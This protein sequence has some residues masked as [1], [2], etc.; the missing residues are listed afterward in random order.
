RLITTLHRSQD[1]EM[2]GILRSTL[3]D[4]RVILS[5]MSG[6]SISLVQ[7]L[8]DLRN[9]ATERLRD[10]G[11]PPAWRMPA[12]NMPDITLDYQTYKNLKS[13]QREVV[14]NV[15]RHAGRC[16]VEFDVN[17]DDGHLTLTITDLR[18]TD[19]GRDAV[20]GGGPTTQLGL[21][22]I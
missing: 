4:L 15:L 18:D 16:R 1:D 19:A 8:S 11:I 2:R 9:E 5:G 12:Q 10:D 13:A 17:I 7:L 21:A 20:P 3:H 14:S 6:E 22:N